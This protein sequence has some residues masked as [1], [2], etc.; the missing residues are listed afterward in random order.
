MICGVCNDQFASSV[1]SVCEKGQMIDLGCDRCMGIQP[2]I[3]DVFFKQPYK[4]EALDVE[5]TSKAQKAA[6]LKANGLSEAGDMKLG[7]KSWIEGTREYR[8]RNFEDARPAIRENYKRYLD[9][10]RRKRS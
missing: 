7:Q 3:H 2:T 4:S 1:K 10:V 6:Y 5:F 8:K 9:N